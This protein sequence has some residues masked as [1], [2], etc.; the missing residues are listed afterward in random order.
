MNE[1]RKVIFEQRKN[2]LASD[3]V[4]EII[5]SFL[6]DLIKDFSE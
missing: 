4:S 2:I 6:E 3:N 1:Q 5:N